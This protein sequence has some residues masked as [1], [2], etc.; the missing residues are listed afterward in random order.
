MG[1]ARADIEALVHET[2]TEVANERKAKLPGSIGDD[3]PIFGGG[4]IL[5]STGVTT[6]V[7]EIEMRLEERHG[8]TVTLVNDRAMSRK[9]SP[10]R[11]VGSFVTYIQETVDQASS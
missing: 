10:F 7:M 1:I 2:F 6:L 11:T 9:N 8:V 3:T 5:D 4:A